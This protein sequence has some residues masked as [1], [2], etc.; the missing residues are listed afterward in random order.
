MAVIDSGS[1]AAGKA[2]VDAG[3]NLMTNVPGYTAAGAVAGGG[4]EAGPTLYCENDPG[5]KTAQRYVRPVEC[6]EDFRA[7]VALDNVMDRD[8]FNYTAQNTGKFTHVFT[9]LTATVSA[10]GL[11]TNSGS[12][13]ATGVGMTHGTH[14]EFPVAH[15][16]T[17]TYIEFHF[18]L[19]QAMASHPANSNIDIGMFRRGA[20]TPFL[21]TDGVYFRFD[22]NGIT[23]VCNNNG[24]EQTLVLPVTGFL[25]NENHKYTISITEREA[26]FW[27]DD[28]RYGN[29]TATSTL[30]Q[31]FRSAS[32]PFSL[33]HANTNVVSSAVQGLLTDYVITYGGPGLAETLGTVGNRSLGSYQG[34][35]GGTM[36]SLATYANST[37]PT[38]AA[39]SN[40]AAN[41]TGLGGQGAINAAATAATDFIMCSYQVPA[42]TVAVQGRRLRVSGVKISA[43]NLGAAVATTATTIGLSLAFGHTAVSLATTETASFATA[44]T[45]AP[46][47]IPLGIMFWNVAAPIGATPQNGDIYMPFQNPIYVN[48]GEFIATTM[49]FLVGTATASQSI[50]Y[51]VTFD[52]GWE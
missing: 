25:A 13:V 22:S 38:S 43:A 3:F 15:G 2:N 33:R 23:A 6:D 28:V 42:G 50:W 36:G 32:L 4:P 52:Y 16:A 51:H 29:L 49:K 18:A 37:N 24:T 46:R 39:G 7:R 41:V 20:S 5:T 30:G 31:L 44:T 45:K 8:T 14:A 35:S 21:P 12:S 9:T 1:S 19:N 34:L 48:P 26:E 47:R 17:A 40:T 10:N 11:L 27:I